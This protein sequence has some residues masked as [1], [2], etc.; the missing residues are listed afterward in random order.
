MSIEHLFYPIGRFSN[1]ESYSD[2]ETVLHFE[3]IRTLPLEL[4][5]VVYNLPE[6]ALERHYRDG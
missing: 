3:Q 1:K 2:E 6:G 4:R 5:E